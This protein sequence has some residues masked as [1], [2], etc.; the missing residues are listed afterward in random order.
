MEVNFAKPGSMCNK[1]HE[2]RVQVVYVPETACSLDR[3]SNWAHAMQQLQQTFRSRIEEIRP[4]VLSSPKTILIVKREGRRRIANH[5]E[6]VASIQ[7]QLQTPGTVFHNSG[8]QLDVYEAGAPP[9]EPTYG[10]NKTGP[11]DTLARFYN[12]EV[13]IGPHGSG[14]SNM[15]AAREGASVID[16]L[17]S[18]PSDEDLAQDPNL[19]NDP[20]I[21]SWAFSDFVRAIGQHHYSLTCAFFT[22]VV[23][24]GRITHQTESIHSNPFGR[25]DGGVLLAGHPGNN[26]LLR[27]RSA[28]ARAKL[29]A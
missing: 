25:L 21:L 11:L 13:V 28:R 29:L 7:E 27:A 4:E 17:L 18:Y 6:L 19:L 23:Q 14:F 26:E 20:A 8:L 2:I 22:L 10:A 12:A 5:D 16:I 3:Q 9:W 1:G 15:I 24:H